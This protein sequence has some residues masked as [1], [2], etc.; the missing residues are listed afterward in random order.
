[1]N[2]LV[3]EKDIMKHWQDD[4]G[5]PLVS[6]CCITFNQVAYIEKTLKGFLIQETTFPIEILIHDDVSNDGTFELIEQYQKL[7]PNLIRCIRP[8]TNQYSVSKFAFIKTFMQQAEGKYIAWCEGDDYWIESK[9]LQMQVDRMLELGVDMSF[10]PSMSLREGLLYLPKGQYIDRVY[11]CS[12]MITC[13]FHF[14]QTNSLV[15]SKRVANELD[16]EFMTQSPVADFFIRVLGSKNTGAVC[17]PKTM[18]VYRVQSFGSWTSKLAEIE[19]HKRFVDCMIEACNRFNVL[20]GYLFSEDFNKYK[21]MLVKSLI[22][23][24]SSSKPLKDSFLTEYDSYLSLSDKVKFYVNTSFMFYWIKNVAKSL[25][26][27]VR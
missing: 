2:E 6:I 24:I 4:S 16:K 26:R 1:M 15:F 22:P 21:S 27:R 18:S 12:E 5:K 14:V 17:I 20:H 25:F 10:H 13:D 19:T 23:N 3:L 9:K 7:Y 11:S 8:E